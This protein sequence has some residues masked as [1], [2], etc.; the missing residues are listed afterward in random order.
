MSSRSGGLC[1]SLC[2]NFEGF[3]DVF[4]RLSLSSSLGGGMSSSLGGG[5]SSSLSGGVRVSKLL[6]A[7]RERFDTGAVRPPRLDLEI[8]HRRR[9][10]GRGLLLCL[11]LL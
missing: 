8:P 7:L 11:Q 1:S 9:R 5:L 6:S 2:S 3:L 4:Q 10:H